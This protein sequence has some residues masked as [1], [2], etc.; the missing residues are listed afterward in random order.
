ANGV[1]VVRLKK[2][3]IEVGHLEM[4]GGYE[5]GERFHGASC[6]AFLKPSVFSIHAYDNRIELWRMHIPSSGVLQYE[7]TY[8]AIVPICFEEE[9]RCTFDFV[10]VLWDLRLL[11]VMEIIFKLLEEHN[12]SDFNCPI[13]LMPDTSFIRPDNDN[14]EF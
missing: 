5:V 3:F 13:F 11:E 6:E 7:R 4:S 10:I 1:F 12:D 9:Q 8:R 14:R 2:L